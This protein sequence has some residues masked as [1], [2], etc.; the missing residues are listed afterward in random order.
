MTVSALTRR[1]FVRLGA[2]AVAAGAA[3]KSTI[4]KPRPVAAESAGGR[5]IRFALVGAGIRGCDLLRAAKQV[6]TGLCVG[7][8][9]L[10]DMRHKGAQEVWGSEFPTTR[11]YRAL[12]DRNDVDAILVATCDHQHRRIVVD[13]CAAGKDVYCEKPMSHTVADGFAM[14]AA[15]QANKRIFQC[16]S[17][18]VSSILYAKAR[19][20]YASGRLGEVHSIDARWNRNTPGGAWI[21][22]VPADASPQNV[23]WESFL[24]DAPPR[25]FDPVRFFRWRLFQD[26]GEGLGGD[27]FVHLI[28]GIHAITGI[29]TVA[30][31][32]YSSGGLYRYKDG[33]DFPDLL[34][35]TYD[36]PD[37]PHGGLQVHLHCNQ[38]NDDGDEGLAFY[39]STGT[40]LMTGR[41][42]TFTPEDVAPRFESYGWG[43]MTAAQRQKGM[44]EWRAAHPAPPPA[45]VPGAVES[46]T[47]PQ[48]YNDTADHI[49]N[50]F[51]AIETREH[52]VED[53]VFGNNAAIGCHLANYSYFHRSIATWDAAAQTIKG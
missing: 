45:L 42:V 30:A 5:R 41:T 51:H 22:P 39:G 34:E 7:A 47:L 31:R 38:N 15:V 19:D 9:D 23:D 11:D 50:F 43:G 44:D 52:V 24:T 33:R 46:F 16:G 1:E 14:M 53:E 29:N 49:A 10:Y 27:L 28:S 40:M 4:L 35:T 21:Y 18:R 8:A 6:P 36:Y 25:P 20:I 26:Y 37:A 12:L 13:A 2:G 48:G 17:Q 3:I 32:A